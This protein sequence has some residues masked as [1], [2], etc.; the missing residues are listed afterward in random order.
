MGVRLPSYF[1]SANVPAHVRLQRT[2]N[3]LFLFDEKLNGAIWECPGKRNR[4]QTA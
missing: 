2:L 4:A 1:P 3:G